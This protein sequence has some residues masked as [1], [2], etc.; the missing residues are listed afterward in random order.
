[1]TQR[2]C[3]HGQRP[4]GC[5]RCE[6]ERSSYAVLVILLFGLAAIYAL[7]GLRIP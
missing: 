5:N 4:E 2:R 3:H 7:V 6:T 1:M